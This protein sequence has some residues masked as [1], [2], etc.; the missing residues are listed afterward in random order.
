M[1]FYSSFNNRDVLRFLL[2]FVLL[3]LFAPALNAQTK[4]KDMQIVAIGVGQTKIFDIGKACEISLNHFE[5]WIEEVSDVTKIKADVTR[6]EGMDY[7]KD[8]VQAY[9][10]QLELD[11]PDNTILVFYGTGHGFNYNENV[12]KYPVFAMH[13]TSKEFT[14]S[15]FNQFRM[16]LEKDIHEVLLSKGARFTITLGELC[17]GLEELPIPESYRAMNACTENFLELFAD[18]RGDIIGASSQRGQ[19]SYTSGL[20]GGIFFNQF[21]QSFNDAVD[22]C[23]ET[24][25]WGSI[26]NDSRARTRDINGQVPIYDVGYIGTPAKLI[27]DNEEPLAQN[28]RKKRKGKKESA[29]QFPKKELFD[30]TE[31]KYPT[32]KYVEK[33]NN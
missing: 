12:L 23:S 16:S 20:T 28:H 22:D 19:L 31:I 33:E 5:K 1:I 3:F 6:I 14:R 26:L 21:L 9:I 18:V 24:P 29:L 8:N 27:P 30:G 10:N 17:N 25:D 15:G 2:P 4:P 7:N 32:I 11:D 13:P